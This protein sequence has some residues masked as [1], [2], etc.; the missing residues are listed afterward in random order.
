MA[1]IKRVE[2]Y[3]DDN[4]MPYLVAE[5]TS[6]SISTEKRYTTPE[7]IYELTKE[8]KITERVK[9]T[10]LMFVFDSAMHLICMSEVS[11]GSI[12]RSIMDVRGIAQT[13]LLSNGIGCILCHN[14]PSGNTTPSD[15]DIMST[16]KVVEALKLLE[17]K[18]LD[19]VVV[20][21]NGYTSMNEANLI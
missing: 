4:R 11:V 15:I 6:Y 16:K 17:L 13:L 3:V 7:D 10:I 20:S 14:H 1:N 12:D 5:E 2:V 18:L 8:L 9:E 19:H 21:R